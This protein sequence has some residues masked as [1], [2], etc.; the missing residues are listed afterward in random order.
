MKSEPVGLFPNL[1]GKKTSI[2]D[3]RIIPA[4]KRRSLDRQPF[5][6]WQAKRQHILFQGACAFRRQATELE[7]AACGDVEQPIAVPLGEIAKRHHRTGRYIRLESYSRQ[8]TIAGPHGGRER[9]AKTAATEWLNGIGSSSHHAPTLSERGMISI[10]SSAS[11]AFRRLCHRP[12]RRAD[13]KRSAITCAAFGFSRRM[14][15][16]TASLP[17]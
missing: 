12:R 2:G 15:S 5:A 6:Q 14:K 1:V 13:R 10:S 4:G 7:A 17:K 8:K 11:T 9:R 3:F 16:R